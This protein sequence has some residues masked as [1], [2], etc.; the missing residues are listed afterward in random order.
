MHRRTTALTALI[1]AAALA[2]TGCTLLPGGGDK[3]ETPS[4]TDRFYSQKLTWTDEGALLDST[5]IEV[6]LDWS[7]PAGE[8]IEIAVMRHQA[9]QK[10]RGSLLM[11][12]G[13]PG[14]SGYDYVRDYAQYV[15]SPDVLQNFDVIGFDPRGVNHSNAVT[16]YT[17]PADRDQYLYGT[18]EAPYGSQGW[19]DELTQREKDY[20][21][22]C[23]ENTGPL[24]AHIDAGSV[25]RDM[26]VIRAVLG[27][28]KIN[29]LGYSYGTYLGTVYAELFPE[30]V[31]RM[32]LDGAV[33]PG[34]SDLEALANQMGG[35]ESALRAYMDDCQL[36][37]P[38]CP[39]AGG[40]DAGM[41]KVRAILDGIDAKGL[42]GS[43]GRE[44]DSAT[45]GT[46]IAENL[47][48]DIFWPDMTAMFADLLRGDADSA[49]A[50]ADDYNG[51]N[52]DGSYQD[53]SNDVY[54]A[55]TCAEGDLGTDDSDA[56]DD[57]AALQQKAPTIG[58]YLGYDD[59]FVLEALC[60]NWPHPV[61][62]LPAEFDAAGAAPILVIGTS[63]DPAT[64]YAN[65]VSL[66]E[67]LDSGV[68]ISYEG[69]GH[70]IYA[71]GVPCIDDTVDAYLLEG[72]V[73]DED[74]KC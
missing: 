16:C 10:S 40:T 60:S 64:P 31:G 5:T 25:A 1:A 45:V 22:A 51:R 32:V 24:L 48:S 28:E 21:A 74:P 8:T 36:N 33:D 65:A 14:G 68:L 58:D 46:A 50:A 17:D 73:P 56:F 39:F 67:Q 70:T 66:A 29:Y 52:P 54:S 47:Y 42:T 7:D 41:A 44:L 62:D 57:I 63:N 11:N 12:P 69:E 71:Q 3:T 53:N 38:G 30:K 49:F 9:T 55:V 43:D 59:T 27:D 19:V 13:G 6:P 15:V 72:T 34:V 61:A 26:D 23:A 35:F 37:D 20:A 4:D 2:L 18:Y